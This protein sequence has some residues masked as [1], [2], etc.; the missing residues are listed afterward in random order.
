MV[1]ESTS[2]EKTSSPARFDDNL[3]KRNIRKMYA[4]RFLINM[5][6]IGP[7][8]IPFFTV[9]GGLSMTQ[10]MLLQAWFMA[11]IFLLEIPTG[12]IADKVGR[13]WSIFLGV[14]VNVIGVLIYTIAPE[15]ILFLIGE[16]LWALSAALVSGADSAMIY[17]T[18]KSG[19]A[20]K[21][22]KGVFNRSAILSRAAL[23]ISFPLGSVIAWLI[24][25]KETMLFIAIPLF[26][27]AMV[28]VT[29]HEPPVARRN[30]KKK[31]WTIMKEG[32]RYFFKHKRLQVLVLDNIAV[33]IVGYVLIW[34][35]QIKLLDVGIGLEYFG[36]VQSVMMLGQ[37]AMI[38]QF[39][40]LERILRSKK[41]V[42][43]FTS[44]GIGISM[45]ILGFSKN[46]VTCII[47]IITGAAFGLSRDSLFESYFNKHL[48]SGERATVI[49][50]I[51]MLVTL[52]H[53][54]INP[55]LGLLMDF[56]ADLTFIA[57]GIL[58]ILA[59]L[60]TRIK[61]EDLKD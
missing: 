26:I 18:L 55:F 28:A 57:M 52:S 56:S 20:E 44:V 36:I 10:V 51:S 21:N 3:V 33:H 24:G 9:W 41:R 7:V 11:W 8:L 54:I 5:H 37:I 40:R 38:T 2:E 31:Y 42:L 48:Q 39:T 34:L 58:A 1:D 4:I 6:F 12:T 45:V 16:L 47:A 25:I 19:N 49:S 35:W 60:L 43:C 13:K 50:T 23:M 61:E 59:C 32:L 30:T 14:T 22:S 17:D 15:F 29:L 53:A 27:G 46:Q